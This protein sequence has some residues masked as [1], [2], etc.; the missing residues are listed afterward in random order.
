MVLCD[1]QLSKLDTEPIGLSLPNT[2]TNLDI[3]S[4]SF[5]ALSELRPLRN[6]SNLQRLVLNHGK[7]QSICSDVPSPSPFQLSPSLQKVEL[8]F[9]AIDSWE[10]VSELHN[11][12]PGLTGLRISHNPL[13]QSLRAPDGRPLSTDDGYMLTIGRLGLLNSLNFS[14][15]R[16]SWGSMSFRSI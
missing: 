1:N 8:A 3:G 6:L 9:N 2:I 15:V 13:Y 16:L 11:V 5:V 10:F 12:F 7:I 4:N 14:P